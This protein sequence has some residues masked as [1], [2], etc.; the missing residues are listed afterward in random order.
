MENLDGHDCPKVQDTVNLAADEGMQILPNCRFQDKKAF[1]CSERQS[2]LFAFLRTQH[3]KLQFLHS[4][5]SVSRYFNVFCWFVFFWDFFEQL[6]VQATWLIKTV[7][8]YYAKCVWRQQSRKNIM[9]L[10]GEN[11][12]QISY[13]PNFCHFVFFFWRISL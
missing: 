1:H 9:L 2:K 3:L 6:I 4:K 7:K 5:I 13:C 10:F 12:L 8:L 11:L